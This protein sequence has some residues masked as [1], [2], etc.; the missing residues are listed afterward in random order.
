MFLLSIR[1]EYI[2]NISKSWKQQ[3]PGEPGPG[4]GRGP[5]LGNIAL[6][7]GY[8]KGKIFPGCGLWV[9]TSGLLLILCLLGWM[10][11][12]HASFDWTGCSERL[13]PTT[14]PL[15]NCTANK[16][17]TCMEALDGNASTFYKV[18]I[19]STEKRLFGE[20]RSIEVGWENPGSIM[21]GIDLST[22]HA[23]LTRVVITP[24][25][26]ISEWDPPPHVYNPPKA[27]INWST[28]MVGGIIQASTDGA[29]WTDLLTI[30]APPNMPPASTTYVLAN[31]TTAS[32]AAYTSFRYLNTKNTTR[33]YFVN[34]EHGP[35][36]TIET[37][38]LASI[39]DI[40]FFGVPAAGGAA[41]LSCLLSHPAMALV[42][43]PPPRRLPELRECH[44]VDAALQ[45][46]GRRVQNHRR[47]GPDGELGGVRRWV[48]RGCVGWRYCRGC[49]RGYGQG[50]RSALVHHILRVVLCLLLSPGRNHGIMREEGD[51]V[52]RVSLL[53]RLLAQR[54]DTQLSGCR[55]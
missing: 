23:I 8:S 32:C 26:N 10:E 9:S 19:L 47:D 16:T 11:G 2:P 28:A 54:H 3:G 35:I 34:T 41:D 7:G 55:G 44:D 45:V 25:P 40:A 33:T 50:H 4:G 15:G 39:A 21:V 46:R 43:A 5:K 36:E 18:G 53:L 13:F 24:H 37:I 6:M 12:C 49:G 22:T 20:L 52:C 38:S 27:Y 42:A 51:V 17:A 48:K 30:V 31:M 14:L 29:V 1:V